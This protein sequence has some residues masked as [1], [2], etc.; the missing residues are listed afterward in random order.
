MFGP[1]YNPSLNRF[2]ACMS[3][4]AISLIGILPCNSREANGGIDHHLLEQ[5]QII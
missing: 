2:Y 3:F 5:G 1:V 4:F